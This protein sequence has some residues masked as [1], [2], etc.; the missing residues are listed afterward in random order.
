MVAIATKRNTLNTLLWNCW[1]QSSE[2]S[3]EGSLGFNLHLLYN[4][5]AWPP[6]ISY[7]ALHSKSQKNYHWITISLGPVVTCFYIG[8]YT[9]IFLPETQALK[10]RVCVCHF[11]GNLY[12]VCWNH[13]PGV[14]VSPPKGSVDISY[15]YIGNKKIS[16]SKITRMITIFGL[17]HWSWPLPYS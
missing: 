11:Y 17:W 4:N 12:Q 3:L 9:K 6:D 8:L 14:K 1:A 2:T 13:D 16:F 10:I 15:T 7:V 5:I